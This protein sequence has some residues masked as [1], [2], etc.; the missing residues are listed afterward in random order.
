M[1][2]LPDLLR[3]NQSLSEREKKLVTVMTMTASICTIEMYDVVVIVA[4]SRSEVR[5]AP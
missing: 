1:R 4:G 2:M 5:V 3:L